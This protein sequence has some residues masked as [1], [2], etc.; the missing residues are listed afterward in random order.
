MSS[1]RRAFLSVDKGTETISRKS[2][3]GRKKK[4]GILFMCSRKSKEVRETGMESG[5]R[6]RW[7]WSSHL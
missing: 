6:T 1:L 2:Q 5:G 4:A 3:T 7:D